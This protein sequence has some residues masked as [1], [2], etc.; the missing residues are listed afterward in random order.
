MRSNKK[1]V[2]AWVLT[3]VMVIAA[4]VIG[5]RRKPLGG[6]SVIPEATLDSNVNIIA[7][8]QYIDDRADLLNGNEERKLSIYNANW[9]ER[10]G[11]IVAF[12]S[13]S[14]ISGDG[15]DY[16]YELS[17]KLSLGEG[18]AL[19]L[20]IKNT[21]EYRFVWGSRFDAVM[22]SQNSGRLANCMD[23]GSWSGDVSDFYATM[24]DIL[25]S[26]YGTGGSETT[27]DGGSVIILTI[28]LAL[29]LLLVLSAMDSAHYRSYH[30]RYY[31]VPTRPIFRPYLFWHGPRYRWYRRRWSV[32]PSP[33]RPSQPS[34]GSHTGGSFGGHRGGGFSSSHRGS[35]FSGSHRGGSFGGHRGGGF[36]GGS[37]GGGFGGR[38]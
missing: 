38:R 32:P 27:S 29:I 30:T 37:R 7:F 1:I 20:V 35:G 33:P 34:S 19:L 2:L 10:Y 11:S 25:V 3:V 26:H 9:D 6:D 22:T 14:G 13:E 12:V 17:E 21:D 36:S 24:N 16:A 23:G 18:D 28:I 31:N 5:Q 15:E 8:Q 4:I